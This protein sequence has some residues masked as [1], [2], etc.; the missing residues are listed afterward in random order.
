MPLYSNRKSALCSER[1][2]VLGTTQNPEDADAVSFPDDYL[3]LSEEVPHTAYWISLALLTMDVASN[4]AYPTPLSN[5]PLLPLL[6]MSLVQQ[7]N[8]PTTKETFQEEYDFIV[9]G[10]GSAGSVVASRLSELP[11]VKVLLLEAGKS[12]PIITDVPAFAGSFM[13]SDIDWNYQ[14]V[15]QK[16]TASSQIK[17]RIKWTRGKALGGSS[18]L[19]SMFY[20]RGNMR[21]YNDWAAQGADGWSEEDVMKYFLKL[22]DNRDQE[23]LANGYHAQGG[24]ISVEKPKYIGE[25]KLPIKEAA[26]QM[27]YKVVDVNGPTQT[28]FYDYQMTIRNGQRCS[29]AKAYLVP[30]ENRTN[31]DILTN[32]F[33]T[34]ILFEN[35]HAI[36]VQFD[37]KNKLNTVKSSKEVI[38]S[39]GAINT[40]QLLMLSGIGPEKVL[41]KI[42]IPVIK[43][44][45]VGENLQ[46][47]FAVPLVF[48]VDSSV[49][50]LSQKLSDPVYVNEYI[51]NRTGSLTTLTSWSAFLEGISNENFG[52]DFP[53]F[54]LYF[55]DV[56]V[57]YFKALYS[58]KTDVYNKVYAPYENKTSFQCMSQIL[59]PRSRGTITLDSRNP[60]DSPI[61]DPNYFGDPKDR[62]DIVEG[63]KVCQSIGT[64]APLQKIGSKRFEIPH[65]ECKEHPID[66]DEYYECLTKSF[67]LT[68]YHPVGTAKMGRPD[69]PTTVVDP[70][71]RV[72][73]IEGLRLYHNSTTLKHSKYIFEEVPHTAYWISLALLTMDVASNSAYPTPLANSP[74]LPL[75]LMSLVQQKNAPTT[76]ETFQEEYDF[77]VVGAGSAGSV[78]ASRLSELP[79]VKVLLLEAGKSPPVITDVPAVWG[80]FMKSDLDWNYQTVPQKNTAN[81]QIKNRIKWPRGKTLGG[82]STL[83]AMLYTRGNM[84]NYNDWAAQ[85]AEG[86]SDEDVGKYF[87]KLED[88]RDQ[89]FLANGYHA[90][91]G[92]ISVE[93]PKYT[94]ETKLP[95]KE[96]AEQMGYKV[97]DVN[98]PTQTGFYDYQMTIR[99]GQRCSTAKAYLV[100]AENRTNLD[101]L[102]NAFVTKILLENNRAIGVQFDYKNKLNTV[103]SSKEVIVSGGAINTPQL[104]MLS[105]IGPKKVLDKISI[106]VIKDLP[107]GENLQD[108]FAV[109]LVF[110]VDSSIAGKS[111]KLSDPVYVNEYIQN[112]TGPLSSV[113]SWLAFLEGKSNEN[114]GAGFP[115]FELY[116][117]DANV[118]YFKASYSL[119]TDVYNE[120]YAPY[121]NKTSFQCVSQI[122]QPRSRGTITLDSRN[123]Y[124]SPIIDP[125]YFGDP[126]D[127]E[128]IVEGLKVC[129]SIGTSAPLQKIGSKRFEIPHPEC[130]E[131][132]IDSDEYY[133]CLTKSFILTIYHPVGTAKMGRPDDPT[134]VVD[135]YLRVKGIEGLR[136]VDASVM[137]IIP[138]GNTNVP[139]IM[140]AEKASDIIKSTINC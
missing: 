27:G 130:K 76:K 137:P 126:K 68:I 19:N 41:S 117:Q 77:I 115:Q 63:L 43:D 9:V 12:P 24:P 36:G 124:D 128:D 138:S 46:D 44:L 111:Q 90:Q 72:K 49:V 28:G 108:H 92:P 6:L 31:L 42:S 32:A 18:I 51:Q 82:S 106:P 14:T 93:K 71:L 102:T 58:L 97:V 132:P 13:E 26:E 109:P 8:A 55:M 78:V 120:V 16:N 88:N 66:S 65:P 91:G 54:Q 37:Y 119:K 30:A 81:S 125:N 29:T 85:G 122:L 136:V 80:S 7:K 86:W 96:A 99:N 17:N 112:R 10:A 35:N 15:P 59:Q 69:D 22:E 62:K 47:H 53:Q 56:N 104:L 103:K 60:Y 123:P 39:G 89:E 20:V 48:S 98:G 38:V 133:E 4:S 101:I 45:P 129:Q 40:P 11:C 113:V 34:K 3:W 131:H 139:T 5:S 127:R 107:V 64:S 95:I 73:G 105:G 2:T 25:T 134:T 1:R 114:F 79:C 94:G 75:L 118:L 121:E 74:L 61:I 116:F 84:R 135:P 50:G 110:S 87:F 52:T 140:V 70:L 33:V 100:P 67:I 23:F 83:N 21:N 57:L